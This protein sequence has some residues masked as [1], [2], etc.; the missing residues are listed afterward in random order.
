MTL[1]LLLNV[2]IKILEILDCEGLNGF[3]KKLLLISFIE[4]LFYEILIWP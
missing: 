3:L 2:E 4:T 1:F